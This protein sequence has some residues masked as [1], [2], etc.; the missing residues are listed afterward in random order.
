MKYNGWSDSYYTTTL[1]KARSG[2]SKNYGLRGWWRP[3]DSGT[4]VPS[5]SLGYDFSSVE[6]QTQDTNA[7]F[8]GL[9]WQDTFTPDDRIGFAFG[10]PQTRDDEAVDPTAWEAY[11]AFKLNDSTT[12]TSTVFGGQ[13]RKGYPNVGS[14][15]KAAVVET[16][17]KF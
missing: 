3:E 16:T 11:Y 2:D 9:G 14:D 17:F 13:E 6:G 5:I 12:I 1:G 4:A 7:Y 8:I 15:F 10:Q